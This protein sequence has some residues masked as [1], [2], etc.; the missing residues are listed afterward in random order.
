MNAIFDEAFSAVAESLQRSTVSVRNGRHSAGSGVVWSEDGLIVTNAHV[1][2]RRSAWIELRDGRSFEGEVEQRDAHSDLAALRIDARD[3]D[4]VTVRDSATLRVGELVI[5]VGNPLGLV[6]S[7]GCGIVHGPPRQ[8]VS[9]DVRLAPGNSGG[10]LADAMGRVVGV[11][12]MTVA[13]TLALAV[14]SN[15]IRRFLGGAATQ[16][17]RLGVALAP[18]TAAADARD[19][20]GFIILDVQPGSA[21]SSAGLLIGD[22]LVAVHKRTLNSVEDIDAALGEQNDRIDVTAIR[23]G[24]LIQLTVDKARYQPHRAA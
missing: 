21:A 14:S 8:W 2:T 9:A 15:T 10:P 24:R 3:L 11:N 5:A 16:P 19:F 6:G 7:V 23:A 4:A 12:S 22:V 18:V 17:F 1:A 20:S 13:G